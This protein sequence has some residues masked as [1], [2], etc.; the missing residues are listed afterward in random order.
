MSTELSQERQNALELA[1]VEG[2]LVSREGRRWKFMKPD[3]GGLWDCFYISHSV[4]SVSTVFHKLEN[5]IEPLNAEKQKAINA[6][7]DEWLKDA[8]P[9]LHQKIKDAS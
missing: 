4:L 1:R 2:W 7:R 9:R 5:Y 8:H 3:T 6:V